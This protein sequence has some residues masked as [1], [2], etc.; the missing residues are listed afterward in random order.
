MTLVLVTPMA[1]VIAALQSAD[2]QAPALCYASRHARG[3]RL[4]G[5]LCRRALLSLTVLPVRGLVSSWRILRS[6]NA[7]P[8]QWK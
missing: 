5:G 8:Q 2:A 7:L 1:T 6:L 3:S 4:F